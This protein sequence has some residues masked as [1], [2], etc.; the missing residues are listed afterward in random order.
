MFVSLNTF[1]IVHVIISLL[2]IASGLVVFYGLLTGKR[3]AG[4]TAFFLATTVATIASGFGFPFTRFLPS[5]AIGVLSL[6]IL[7]VAIYARYFQRDSRGWQRVYV[8]TALTALYF[9]VFVLV[10]QSFQKIPMLKP[11]APTQAEA[12]FFLAQLAVLVA[13]LILGYRATAR[14]SKTVISPL[15]LR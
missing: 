15:Q 3:F 5:H 13:F 7:A 8:A 11:L 12:P 14:T 10:V 9:N 4:L 2:A 6:I 1:T